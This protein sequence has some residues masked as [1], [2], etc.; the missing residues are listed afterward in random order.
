MNYTQNYQLCLWDEDDRILMEDFNSDNEKLETALSQLP[1]KG[2]CQ[3]EVGSYTGTGFYGSSRN[4]LSFSGQPLLVLVGDSYTGGLLVMIRGATHTT[5][6][7]G[8]YGSGDCIVTCQ[9]NT[10]N[11][12]TWDSS[13]SAEGQANSSGIPYYYVALLAAGE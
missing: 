10:P 6:Y 9:W 1:Q 12:L 8:Q 11:V 13:E 3:I 2:N 4:T 7:C 5:F